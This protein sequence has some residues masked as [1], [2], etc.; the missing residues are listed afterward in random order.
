MII[1]FSAEFTDDLLPA[2]TDS[3]QDDLIKG[4]FFFGGGFSTLKPEP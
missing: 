1:L 3:S 4:V 2:N